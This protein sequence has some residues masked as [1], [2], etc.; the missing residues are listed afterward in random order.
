MAQSIHEQAAGSSEPTNAQSQQPSLAL[1]GQYSCDAWVPG[2]ILGSQGALQ[3]CHLLQS[4]VLAVLSY[5]GTAV[6]TQWG[7]FYTIS[8]FSILYPHVR[9]S[10][11]MLQLAEKFLCERH[12]RN[13]VQ[14]SVV[15]W[16]ASDF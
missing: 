12:E 15:S 10:L 2:S 7:G 6:W 11:Q 14:Y 4:P 3:T 13:L 16:A 8:S 1:S 9:K 5:S